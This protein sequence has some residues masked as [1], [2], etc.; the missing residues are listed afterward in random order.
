MSTPQD[1]NRKHN[2]FWTQWSS[3]FLIAIVATVS[4]TCS[5]ASVFA[6]LRELKTFSL[7]LHV[8]R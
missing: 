1:Q 6:E 3:K 8:S 7:G 2:Q 5:P 4:L